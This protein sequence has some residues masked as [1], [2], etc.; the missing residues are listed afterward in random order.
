MRPDPLELHPQMG[1]LYKIQ[2]IDESTEHYWNGNC[3]GNNEEL[4]QKPATVPLFSPQIPQGL[5]WE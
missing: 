1:L 4:G 5:P 2:L 3:Q